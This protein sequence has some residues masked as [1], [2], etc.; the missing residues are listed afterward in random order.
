MRVGN[1]TL[2]Q[3]YSDWDR[4]EAEERGEE[5]PAL[6]SVSD[7]SIFLEEVGL[8]QTAADLGFDAIHLFAVERAQ[9]CPE[10]V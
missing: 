2:V 5:V 6:P 7:Q 4:Y 3:N 1:I 9:V 8:A 10:F